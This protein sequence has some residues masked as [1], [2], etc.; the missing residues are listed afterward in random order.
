MFL[1]RLVTF[2]L[3]QPW[4]AVAA[5]LLRRMLSHPSLS[6][7]HNPETFSCGMFPSLAAI[8]EAQRDQLY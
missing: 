7:G 8:S 3:L 6:T 4:E 1:Q 5:D 2:A